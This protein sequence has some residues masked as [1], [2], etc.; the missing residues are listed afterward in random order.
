[1]CSGSQPFKFDGGERVSTWNSRSQVVNVL[2]LVSDLHQ[3]RLPR[4]Q[5]L[6]FS[7]VHVQEGS[8]YDQEIPHSHTVPWGR[9][10]E[11]YM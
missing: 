8:E 1:M 7:D 10:T 4:D 11:H 9:A 6:F 3:F 2:S 5:H